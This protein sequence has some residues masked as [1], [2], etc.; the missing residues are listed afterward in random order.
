MKSLE[1]SSGKRAA[2]RADTWHIFEDHP[3]MGTGLGTLQMVFA[4]YDTLYDGRVVNHAHNDY[5]EAL[6]ETGLAGGLC[7]GLFLGMLFFHSLRLLAEKRTSFG[8][9]LNLSG[10]VA[11]TGFLVHSFV[12]FN[13]RIP[14]NALLFFL[15]AALATSPINQVKAAPNDSEDDGRRLRKA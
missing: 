15:M 10:L 2:M 11:C 4:P 8:A 9:I 3:W 7:C 13:L 14:G 12:D 1:V 6:A 5:L